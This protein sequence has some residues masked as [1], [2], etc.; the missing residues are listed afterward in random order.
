VGDIGQ[1]L[2]S[3]G[4]GKYVDLFAENEIDFDVLGQLTLDELKDLGVPLGA[5]KRILNAVATLDTPPINALRDPEQT[6]DQPGGEAERRQLTVMFCDLVGSTALSE[7]MDPEQL[8]ELIVAYQSAARRAIES[9]EGYIARYMGDGLLIYFGYPQAHEDDAERAV[10]A[11]LEI[12]REVGE[13]EPAGQETLRVRVGIATGLVVAGDIVGEGAS[14][15]RAVLGDTPNLAARLQGLASPNY[16]VIADSTMRLVEGMFSL[17]PMP[18]QRLKGISS[19]VVAYRVLG[20][21]DARNRFDAAAT[22]GLSPLVGREEETSLLLRR[23]E[24]AKDGEGQ[25]VLL[26]GEPGV[27]KSRLVRSFQESA[28]G[29]LGSR[30]LYFCSPHF[31]TSALHPVIDQLERAFQFER[32]DTS[33]RRLEKL[34]AVLNELGL[35]PQEHGSALAALL[36]LPNNGRYPRQQLGPQELRQRTFSALSAIFRARAAQGPLLIIV[37]DAHWID[38]ST[39]EFL[40]LLVEDLRSTPTLLLVTHRP[41][42]NPGFGEHAYTTVLSLNRLAR[43]QSA[44]LAD[45]VAGK[46][47][48]SEVVDLIVAKTDGVPLFV[49][50][51]TKTVLDSGFLTEAGDKYEIVGELPDL[52]IPSSLQDSLAARLDRLGPAKELA[53]L[54]AA[55]GRSFGYELLSAVSGFDADHLL[56]L[57]DRLLEAELIYRRGRGAESVYEF[58]H[59]LVQEVAYESLLKSKRQQIHQRIAELLELR[60]PKMA[61]AQPEILAQHLTAAGRDVQ[62]VEYWYRAGE[63]ASEH[64][65]NME[66]IEHLNAGLALVREWTPDTNRSR[67]ELELLTLLGPA[68]MATKGYGALAV[69]DTYD[70]AEALAEATQ[71]QTQLFAVLFGLWLWHGVRAQFDQAR[72]LAERLM[73]LAKQLEDKGLLLQAHH[74]QWMTLY[75]HGDLHAVREHC[76]QGIT[77]YDRAEHGAHAYMYGG[78]DPGVCCRGFLARVLW[79]QGSPDRAVAMSEDGLAVAAALGHPLT[80]TQAHC[81]AAW[82]H[83]LR[84]DIVSTRQQAE[85]TMSLSNEHGFDYWR[86]QARVLLGWVDV[87]EGEREAGVR[88]MAQ[89]LEGIADLGTRIAL[90]WYAVLLAEGQAAQGTPEVALHTVDKALVVL[91]ETNTRLLRGH[92]S[93]VGL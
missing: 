66:A 64:S 78:H 17:E 82:V 79:F 4:L 73:A 41:E 56:S 1:W 40:K 60:F 85:A 35:P 38:P 31:Q 22:R 33:E 9:Y 57:L 90:P 6:A 55:I 61:E 19:P 81:W 21:S 50:E 14:E 13:Y 77:L 23:W 51:L 36:S 39:E 75:N 45:E 30:A 67:R 76:E 62:A 7:S 15:E 84:H 80:L 49:E 34:D 52:G 58:K 3:N 88:A 53:Q 70:R 54:A 86:E 16:V 92:R 10:R 29:E 28:D 18:P 91:E 69:K 11:G 42:Y 74:A 48:P 26:S 43:R 59:V 5:R 71:D 89:G 27:G 20:M 83:A 8:R 63:R 72:S 65:A 24:Q 2:E 32:R 37:E 25:I 12:V 93:G 46:G 87:R 68:I 47:L 44:A